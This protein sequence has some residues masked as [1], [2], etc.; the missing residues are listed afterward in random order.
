[1]SAL[2]EAKDAATGRFAALRAR[3]PLLDHVV[4]TFQHYGSTNASMLAG[5]TTYFGF[6]SIFPLL[7]LAF[8]AVGYVARVYPDA[9]DQ[10]IEAIE[11]ILPGMVSNEVPAPTGTISLK[12]IE[13]YAGAVGLVG[14]VGVLY[15]GLSW[16]SSMRDALLVVFAM[17][18]AERPNMIF[19]KLRDLLT[20]GVVGFILLFTVALSGVVTRLSDRILDW[21][22]V[23][24][25]LGWV[26][27]VISLAVALGASALL[28]FSLFQI[29]ARPDVRARS[30]WAGALLGAVGFELLKAAASW[31]IASTKG[32]PA[33]QAFGI[34]LMLLVWINYFSRV[35]MLAAAWSQTAEQTAERSQMHG[36]EVTGAPPRGHGSTAG[37]SRISGGSFGLGALA[38]VLT[39]VLAVRR[40]RRP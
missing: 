7:A 30:L 29:L 3:F 24:E 27:V 1:M 17:P 21:L 6:L 25:S 13:D 26:V 15:S 32:Q 10:L 11:H 40:R 12:T 23:S 5:A 28:V 18:K 16:V 2:T 19:G 35:V 34:S 9:Q 20:L 38:G 4:R 8:F 36:R 22:G 39:T 37:G 31:L 14:V 33:F